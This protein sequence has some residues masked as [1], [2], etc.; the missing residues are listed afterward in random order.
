MAVP[1]VAAKVVK[2]ARGGALKYTGA[3]G[4]IKILLIVIWLASTLFT[5]SSAYK[6]D[7]M[8]G[9]GNYL[10]DEVLIP[11]FNLQELSLD[12]I[13]RDGIYV[14]EGNVFKSFW[15]L[16]KDYGKII[17]SLLSVYIWIKFLKFFV[18]LGLI[19]DTSRIVA[20]WST[21]V[22]MF[23]MIQLILIGFFQQQ[24]GLAGLLIPFVAV[25]DFL[26]S[27]PF[28]FPFR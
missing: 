14:S 15:N 17:Y 11:T 2:S 18:L 10:S 20:I 1:I 3:V 9:I 28:L 6:N 4:F 26:R 19:G 13:E 24:T 21:T 12:I 23:F 22:V 25:W 8:I 7:G 5:L 27:I 16:L